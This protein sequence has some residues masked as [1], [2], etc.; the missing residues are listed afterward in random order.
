MSRPI[1]RLRAC[2]G[3][4]S[5]LIIFSLVPLFTLFAFVV[6]L[7]MLVNAKIALQNAADLAAYAGAATQARQLTSISHINYEM[8]EA[9][10]RFIFR[11]YV[12]GNYAL[13][14][15]PRKGSASPSGTDPCP[16]GARS[17]DAFDW[18]NPGSLKFPGVPVVCLDLSKDSNP[19]QLGDSVKLVKPPN[20]LPMDPVC[21][22]L[23][24]A[25]SQIQNIQLTACG[26]HKLMNFEIALQWLYSTSIN[27]ALNTQPALQELIRG[28]GLVPEE[29]LHFAR[30]E[31]LQDYV[32]EPSR[33]VTVADLN[34]IEEVA[35]QA[36]TE[37]SVLAFKTA[38]G[39]LNRRIDNTGVFD[40]DSVEMKELMPD[41]MLLIKK[42]TP[43]INVPVVLFADPCLDANDNPITGCDS[44]QQNSCKLDLT[45]VSAKPI[46]GVYKEPDPT[47]FYAIKLKAK[48]RLLFNPFPF[49]KSPDSDGIELTA[50][51]AAKPFGSRIGPKLPEDAFYK[52]G[53][54]A[55]STSISGQPIHYPFLPINDEWTYEHRG[56]LQALSGILQYQSQGTAQDLI[57]WD[58]LLRALNAAQ[59][60]DEDEVGKYNIPVNAETLV[61]KKNGMIHYFNFEAPLRDPNCPPIFDKGNSVYTLWAPILSPGGSFEELKERMKVEIAKNITPWETHDANAPPL[62]QIKVRISQ[63][64]RDQF[65]T[66]QQTLRSCNNFNVARLHDPLAHGVFPEGGAPRTQIPG[67]IVNIHSTAKLATSYTTD[68]A[69]EYYVPGRDGYSVKF[70]AMADALKYARKDDLRGEKADVDKVRH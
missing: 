63:L 60:P 67:K 48:A 54:P 43:T 33:T 29:I 5:I 58:S 49:G 61:D 1:S 70:I 44:N 65:S 57:S 6:N 36:R 53:Q 66:Y 62:E 21:Q 24:T 23:Q 68:K 22:A 19:C 38:L 13:R 31:T 14:C 42:I 37:R 18:I 16:T 3:Q 30:I 34:Q 26:A 59:F 10:K 12:I 27:G 25:A 50:Y 52:V 2:S 9:Y 8:R 32:N 4:I 69:Q 64:F 39:N 20:C 41:Y 47:V 56:V 51:A 46:V 28:P 55:P 40:W 7:G 11:Y 17:E 45:L 35:D 15:F